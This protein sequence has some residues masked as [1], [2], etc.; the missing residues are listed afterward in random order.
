[1]SLNSC[2]LPLANREFGSLLVGSSVAVRV[3][4]SSTAPVTGLVRDGRRRAITYL[5]DSNQ[6]HNFYLGVNTSI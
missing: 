3:Q 4:L 1:M 6:I 5:N 2:W